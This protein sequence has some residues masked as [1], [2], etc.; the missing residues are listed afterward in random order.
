MTETAGVAAETARADGV[1]LRLGRARYAVPMHSIAEVGRPPRITRVPGLPGWLA[2]VVNWRG[3]I[4]GVLDLRLLL[5]AEQS[6][7]DAS[8]RLLV[9]THEGVL[10]GLLADAV[11][12]TR[13]LPAELEPPPA[14]VTGPAADL[15]AGHVTDDDGPVAVLDVAAVFRLRDALPRAARRGA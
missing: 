4:L 2:G 8:A 7:P 5:A 14:T 10:V 12:G 15:L 11:T 6:E 13:V 3:R 9:L 1:V